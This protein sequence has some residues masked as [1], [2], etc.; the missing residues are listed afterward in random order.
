MQNKKSNSELAYA[1]FDAVF[2]INL[3]KTGKSVRIINNS[4][5]D[6]EIALRM[7]TYRAGQ[8]RFLG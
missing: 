4:L 7:I 2:K 1:N 5:S 8:E 3:C 6:L